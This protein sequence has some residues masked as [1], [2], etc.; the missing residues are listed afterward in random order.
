LRTSPAFR[1]PGERR[2]PYACRSCERQRSYPCFANARRNN[3]ARGYG[4]RRS[5]GRRGETLCASHRSSF[6]TSVIVARKSFCVSGVSG[7]LALDNKRGRRN[8]ERRTLVTAAACFPDR[9]ET[10]AHGNASRRPAAATSSTLGPDFRARARASSPS[11]QVS[12]PF[13]RLV[14][15]LKAA[16]RSGHGR[17]P[18][19]PRV[20]RE[21]PPR[22][23]APHP[24][25]RYKRPGNAPQEG[26][27][28]ME[29]R[30][31]GIFVKRKNI[32]FLPASRS[33]PGRDAALLRRCFAE[34]GPYQALPSLRPRLSSA[35]LRKC[36]ALRSIRGTPSM[37]MA[38]FQRCE[39][40]RVRP[41]R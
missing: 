35:P 23:Q 32:K 7:D 11:R 17:L 39:F 37:L 12:P 29:C 34:P 31:V 21:R 27:D 26:R 28:R 8:A 13:A 25:P 38:I 16:P 24:A 5:P 2:D 14:Q 15:P 20:R 22:P 4:S 18:K 1:R 3:S 33:C 19:A 10:E 41:R 40:R 30:S 36:Y 9:R 6:R